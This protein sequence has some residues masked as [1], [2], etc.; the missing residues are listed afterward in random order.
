MYI[1]SFAVHPTF[2]KLLVVSKCLLWLMESWNDGLVVGGWGYWTVNFQI[3]YLYIY[4]VWTTWVGYIKNNY[5]QFYH[6]NCLERM[7]K[8]FSS[9]Q[10]N[11]WWDSSWAGYIKNNCLL[12]YYFNCLDRMY[13]WFS[14][15]QLYFGENHLGQDTLKIITYSFIVFNCMDRMY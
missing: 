14:S 1:Y 7:Y 12:F 8:W 10:L 2:N 3:V 13:K 15:L 9:L 4:L 11:I 6:F 5:L